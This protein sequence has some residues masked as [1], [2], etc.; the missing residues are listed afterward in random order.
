MGRYVYILLL[1][2][3][4]IE[5]C[6]LNRLELI[7]LDVGNCMKSRVFLRYYYFYLKGLVFVVDSMNRERVGVVKEYFEE[8]VNEEEFKDIFIVIVLYKR[9]LDNCM[10]K[11][12][13][14]E[15]LEVNII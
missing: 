7:V 5:I 13:M 8:F 6:K 11:E 15:I 2:I 10:I 4:N 14:E 12:E 9:D 3:D 1:F